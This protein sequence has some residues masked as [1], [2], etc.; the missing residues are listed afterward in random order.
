L[1]ILTHKIFGPRLSYDFRLA[2]PKPYV[3]YDACTVP[4]AAL[5]QYYVWVDGASTPIPVEQVQPADAKAVIRSDSYDSFGGPHDTKPQDA[6]ERGPVKRVPIGKIVYARSGDKGGNANVGFY[7]RREEE[8]PWL[9]ETLSLQCI[10]E[11]MADEDL[12]ARIERVEMPGILAVHFVCHDVLGEKKLT[13][14]G[15]EARR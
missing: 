8:Y 4:I 1:G 9:C 11:L 7:V 6:S 13:Q 3:L 14:F 5:S 15:R 12:G 10:R 2:V